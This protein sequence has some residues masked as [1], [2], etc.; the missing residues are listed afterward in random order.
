MS[1]L[2]YGPECDSLKCQIKNTLQEKVHDH[3]DENEVYAETIKNM[4][5]KSFRY[6]E[7]K[8]V[9]Q[10]LILCVL[11]FIIGKII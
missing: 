8:W 5:L 1:I 2:W 7:L 9:G 10:T 6:Y 4:I 11:F 3:L